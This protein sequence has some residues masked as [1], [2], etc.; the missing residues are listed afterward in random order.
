MKIAILAWGSLVWDPR[1]LPVSGK[2]QKKGPTLPIEFSRVSK[3]KRLTLVI[4]EK[5]GAPVESLFFESA[6]NDLDQA[7]A[8]LKDREET[9]TDNIGFVDLVSGKVSSVAQAAHPNALD[10]IREWAKKTQD[11]EIP[12]SRR[13]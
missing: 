1:E 2:A 5:N 6:D 9:K 10:A 13:R 7:I 8:H 3:D 11:S 4:D 12:Q